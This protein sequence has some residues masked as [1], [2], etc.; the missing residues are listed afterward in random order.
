MAK[1]CPKGLASLRHNLNR[2]VKIFAKSGSGKV[3][4]RALQEAEMGG[5]AVRLA[6]MD[7]RAAGNLR[8]AA[9]HWRR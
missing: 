2:F 3:M 7:R 6:V 4:G 9:D 8:T 1:P 5:E